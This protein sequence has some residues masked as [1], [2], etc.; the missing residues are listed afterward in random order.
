MFFT[1]LKERKARVATARQLYQTALT[2]SRDPVFYAELGVADT[3]DGRFDVLSLHATL[4]MERLESLGPEGRK[5]AQAFFDVLFKQMELTLREI[6]VGD[7]GVP[8]H[9]K[10]MMKGFHG[11]AITYHAAMASHEHDELAHAIARNVFRTDAAQMP[12]GARVIAYYMKKSHELIRGNGI[13][14][15]RAGKVSFAPI[16]QLQQKEARYA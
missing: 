7:L 14:D 4:I 9:M 11:R 2:Q 13:D 5:L 8:K 1:W 6:G 15:F 16:L 3:M 10:K 12:E